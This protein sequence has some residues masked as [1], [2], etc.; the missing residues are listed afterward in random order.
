MPYL[1]QINIAITRFIEKF[2]ITSPPKQASQDIPYFAQWESPKRINDFISNKKSAIDDPQ[3]ANSG[4]ES[5]EQYSLWAPHICGMASFKM[6]L[7]AS[8]HI[9]VPT[10]DLAQDCATFGG[11][12]LPLDQ[13]VGLHY[14]AFQDFARQKY[15]MKTT[16]ARPLTL[17]KIKK[18]LHRGD[19]VI[20][21]VSS[22]I[23]LA[24]AHPS[25]TGHLVVITGYNDDTRTITFHNPG[26]RSDQTQANSQLTYQHFEDYFNHK[27]LIIKPDP[28]ATNFGSNEI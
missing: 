18:S 20:A 27:G 2:D 6:I 3:W 23:D 14:R 10:I 8:Q 22:N 5:A 26:G 21:S 11:Y 24:P 9:S 19:F 12:K 13:H 1:H 28:K 4:A 15:N 7:A 25:N 16:I 17:H